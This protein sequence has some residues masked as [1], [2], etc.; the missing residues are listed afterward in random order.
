MRKWF[1]RLLT[2]FGLSLDIKEIIKIVGFGG[3]GA[4]FSG[5]IAYIKEASLPQIA[6]VGIGIFIILTIL[7]AFIW[8][9]KKSKTLY[10]EEALKSIDRLA[11]LFMSLMA[12]KNKNK[13]AE[14]RSQINNEIRNCPNEWMRKQIRLFLDAVVEGAELGIPATTPSSQ[15][16]LTE[17]SDRMSGYAYKHFR[18]R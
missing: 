7:S 2:L 6:L 4:V 3:S 13:K 1:K 18:S 14:I 15:A 10:L 12:T 9:Y 11:E 17:W 16:I 8:N 5:I